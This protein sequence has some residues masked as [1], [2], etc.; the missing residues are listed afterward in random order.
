MKTGRKFELDI[1]DFCLT[2]GK[3][4]CKAVTGQLMIYEI[5][6]SIDV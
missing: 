1:A 4:E 5:L 6:T 2:P 3:D